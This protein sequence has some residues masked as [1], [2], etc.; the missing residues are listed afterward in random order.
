MIII[1]ILLTVKSYGQCGKGHPSGFYHNRFVNAQGDTLN[2][3]DSLGYFEGLHVYTDNIHNVF[4]DTTTYVTGY[5]Q[6]GQAIG[7]WTYHCKDGSRSVG[8]FQCGVQC[9]TDETGAWV[10]KKQ[11]IYAQKGIWKYYDTSGYLFLTERYDDLEY[12][13][14]W[15]KKTF[16]ADSNGTLIL[17]NSETTYRHS[18]FK[19]R[20]TK[21]YSKTGKLVSVDHRSILKCVSYKYFENGNVREKNKWKTFFGKD[22]TIKKEYTYKGKLLT[23]TKSKENNKCSDPIG[24]IEW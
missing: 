17:I 16:V 14:K 1:C 7:E 22:I 9:T 24:Y 4:N 8:Q 23:K 15:V 21:T 18:L 11:G 19:K 10:E 3:D 5:Y 2:K 12:K 20:I 6:H 13:N